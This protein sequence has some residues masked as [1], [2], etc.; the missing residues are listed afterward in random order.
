MNLNALTLPELEAQQEQ[1]LNRLFRVRTAIQRR[2]GTDNIE[3]QIAC[4][5]AKQRDFVSALWAARGQTVELIDLEEQ[6]WNGSEKTPHYFRTFVG[7][8]EETFANNHI[9]LFIDSIKQKN[10]D[11]KGYRIKKVKRRNDGASF[12]EQK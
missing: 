4:L 5:P 2:K 12:L 1:L 3:Q 7:R 10:G 11:L 9:P 6:V 8:I